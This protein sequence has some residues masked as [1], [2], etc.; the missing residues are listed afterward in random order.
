MICVSLDEEY[1][2]NYLTLLSKIG[3]AEIRMDRMPLSLDDVRTIF[4]HPATL[5]ATYRPSHVDDCTRRSY[6]FAAIDSGASYVDVE[7]DSDNAY[8]QEIVEKARSKGCKVIISFH[9]YEKTPEE[10]ELKS[11]VSLCFREGAQIVKVACR[12]NVPADNG[13]LLG[14]FGQE[15]LKGRLI[16]VGMGEKG[17]IT[18]VAATYLGSP[19]TFACLAMGKETAEGQ[20]EKERLEEIMGLI[21]GR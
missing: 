6:L 15:D 11:I 3:F 2:A 14:L 17:R 20:I 8:K 5:I 7:V 9:D 21:D 1:T 13:R 18:R 4:S 19:F 10:E 16:V 12:V